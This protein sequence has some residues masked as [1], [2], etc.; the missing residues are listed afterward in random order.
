MVLKHNQMIA[1][2]LLE[3]SAEINQGKIRVLVEDE[4]HL[5]GGDICGYGW[6]NRKQRLDVKVKNYLDS[7]TYYGALN[8]QSGE[9]FL[10]SYRTADTTSTIKFIQEL[11]AQ[12]PNSKILLI[13]D[14][15]SHHRSEK[16][17]DFLAQVN[18]KHDWKVHCLRFA[19]Y[20]PKENPIENVWGQLKQMLRQMYLRCRS[21][22]FTTLLFEMLVRYQLFALPNLKEHDAFSSIT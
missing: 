5:K 21:F 22:K 13:W 3:H 18:Q 15:A 14:G 4:C 20:A 6:A 9:M 8:C 10:Q 17:R 12:D 7:Q 16:L 1:D 19:P 2:W 11:L